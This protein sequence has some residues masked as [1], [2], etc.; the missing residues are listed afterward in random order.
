MLYRTT[1]T[2]L[3][4]IEFIARSKHRISALEALSE[5]PQSRDE[6][7][8]VTGASPSTIGRM[9]REFEDRHWIRRN[10]HQYEA[11]ELG[12]FVT[13][14]I[15]ELVDRI[16]TGQKLSDVWQWLPIEAMGF[17]IEMAS[18]AVVT[19]AESDSPYG[20][21][22]RFAS[23]L[24]EAEE[25]RF[26]GF[27]VALLEPC[28]DEL[29][30]RIVDGMQTEIID[31]PSVAK[32]ILSTYGEHCAESL[33]SD[34]FSVLLHDELPPY[35]VSLFDRRIAISGYNPD[36]GTVQVLIDTDAK[37]AREWAEATFESYRDEARAL[38]L[39]QVVE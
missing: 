5:R 10:E 4:D 30:R 9:L 29:R 13:A 18:D 17:T 36:S 34:D 14:G 3:D 38:S 39:E 16:E 28:R 1:A 23:L 15:T 35:G 21:V 31:P 24:R 8:A 12:A 19:V 20:P 27:D 25:F 7:S 2:P 37:A 32:Y 26:V 22:N 33:E 11:T 6:L